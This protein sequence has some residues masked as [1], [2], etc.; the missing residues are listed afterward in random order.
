MVIIR[1]WLAETLDG[2]GESAALNAGMWAERLG[3]QTYGEKGF[4]A[5]RSTTG[6][7]ARYVS[8]M[9]EHPG[10]G[11]GQG[12]KRSRILFFKRVRA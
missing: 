12:L 5:R 3:R 4:E 9:R 8:G 11:G 2:L 10:A 7:E 6:L 1:V